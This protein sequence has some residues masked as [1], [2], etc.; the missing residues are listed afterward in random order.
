MADLV[1]VS[2]DRGPRCSGRPA[3]RAP[4]RGLLDGD[5]AVVGRLRGDRSASSSLRWI[6]ACWRAC[7]CWMA[8]T[9]TSVIDELVA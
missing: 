4:R 2:I 1:R 3:P 6:A 5:E 7:V 8:N 9:I